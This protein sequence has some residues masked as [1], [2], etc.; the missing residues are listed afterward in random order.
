MSVTGSDWRGA[1]AEAFFRES[2]YWREWSRVPDATADILYALAAVEP[3]HRS[4]LDVP[5][6]RGRLLRAIRSCRSDM[7]LLGF[8][9]NA[10]MVRQA[11]EA[12]PGA[13]VGVASVYSIPLPDRSVDLV[14]CHESFMHFEDPGAALGEL[15]RVAASALYVSVTTRRQLNT[16][17]R[18]LGLLGTSDLPHW[19]YNIEDLRPLL[20]ACDFDWTVVGAFL[21]GAKALRLSHE[22]HRRLHQRFGRRLPQ[23]LL[24]RFGQ[25]LFAYGRRKA[26]PA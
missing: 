8:D 24:R 7:R 23:W 11:R 16:P 21:F 5:C 18:R 3:A 10:D 17:L 19:R 9:I 25:T 1:R 14:M 4:V 13:Q 26:T 15:G 12:V 22:T 2:G 6:G 20:A